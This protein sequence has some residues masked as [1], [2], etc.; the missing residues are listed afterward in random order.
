MKILIT[1]THFTPAQAVIEELKKI[2]NLEIVYVGRSTTMEG[3]STKSAES[4][5]LPK[6]GVKF[7]PLVAGRLSRIL[8]IYS[9]LSIFKIP[10]GFLQSFWIVLKEQPNLTL[11]FGGYVSVPIVFSSYLLSVPIITHEQTLVL[12]LANK[13]NSLFA[14]KVAVSFDQ[15]LGINKKKIVLTGNP[16]RKELLADSNG[17][18]SE[19]ERFLNK[20]K[21]LPIIYITGGNQGSR[22]I[23]QK[24]GEI[25]D[26]LLDFAVI[27]HQTGDSKFHDYDKLIEIKKSLKKPD[28]F[29]V[30]K[31]FQADDVK[32]ILTQADLVICRSGLNTLYELA[33]FG[34]PC[35]TIPLPY[36]YKNEQMV[37]AK[38][39]SQCDL[40]E[41]L[42]QNEFSPQRLLAK[43]KEMIKNRINL[44]KK[45]Q[46]AK[47]VVIDNA[48]AR[49]TKEA[50][51]LLE[52][53][54]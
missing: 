26:K 21:N 48:A 10:I 38:F 43:T 37:N 15:D 1:G 49:V 32:L 45:A 39:F 51:I 5:I 16:I 31:W 30:S 46:K 35:L 24:V 2:P 12:G 44:K 25:L 14:N 53:Y 29:L 27:I 20:Q 47:E 40:C 52:N 17:S 11:S 42:P 18:N 54:E 36:L 4:Q 41:I 13:F 22:E 19:V 23:N 7:V 34:V 9:L 50:L 6:L 3:D 33:F 8:S 28:K